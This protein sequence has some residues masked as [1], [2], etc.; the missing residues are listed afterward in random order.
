MSVGIE[1][2]AVYVPQYALRLTDL[3]AARG[4]PAEKMTAGLGVHEMAIPAACDDRQPLEIVLSDMRMPGMDGASLLRRI[5]EHHPDVA[6]VMVTAVAE[7]EVAVSCLAAGAMDYITKPFIFEEVK[8]RV[9][10]ALEKRRLLLENRGYQ[11]RLEERVK[12]QAQ[13]LEDLFLASVQSLAEALELKDPYTRGHS[14]RVSRYG[15]AISR[16]LGIDDATIRNIE[17]GGQLHDIGKIGVRE[18][19]LNKPGPLTKEEYQHIMTHPVLGWRILR[20]LLGD[21]SVALNIVRSHHERIDGKGVPDGLGGDEIAREARIIAV[22]DAFDAMMSRRPYRKG[23]S[24]ADT[25]DEL[26]RMS[27]TQ[28]DGQVVDAFFEAVS[29]GAIVLDQ[30]EAVLDANKP[31]RLA[32]SAS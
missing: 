6:V 11:E 30:R 1:R 17:L 16:V 10:Q 4:V 31:V 20:P 26:K 28:F 2:L 8:A 19:V 15:V 23:L 24:Y 3:A 29:T 9:T 32:K 7:V 22:A 25:L 21:D 12:A 14:I 13:R 18:D 5:R 27:G